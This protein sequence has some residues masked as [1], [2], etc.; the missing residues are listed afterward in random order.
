MWNISSSARIAYDSLLSSVPVLQSVLGGIEAFPGADMQEKHDFGRELLTRIQSKDSK[1][2]YEDRHPPIDQVW[3]Q[4]IHQALGQSPRW[5]ELLDKANSFGLES[6]NQAEL[7]TISWLLASMRD[8]LAAWHNWTHRDKEAYSALQNKVTFGISIDIESKNHEKR[9]TEY[10]Q[11]YDRYNEKLIYK[12]KP[13]EF[14][15]TLAD[16]AVD[17]ALKSLEI[18]RSGLLDGNM[19]GMSEPETPE[20]VSTIVQ[21]SQPQVQKILQLMGKLKQIVDVNLHKNTGKKKDSLRLE[22]GSDVSRLIVDEYLKDDDLF[23]LEF[24]ERKLKQYSQ[25]NQP[26]GDGP[27]VVIVD[28]TSSMGN[29]CGD[30]MRYEWA[31]AFALLVSSIASKQ[32]RECYFIGFGGY[33]KYTINNKD[34]RADKL[35]EFMQFYRLSST[36]WKP[37]IDKALEIIN[38]DAKFKK[39]DIMLITDGGDPDTPR[40]AEFMQNLATTKKRIDL[41]I[42]GIFVNAGTATRPLELLSAVADSVIHVQNLQDTQKLR[43]ALDA[44]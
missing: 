15:Q 27:I 16:Y 17:S 41:K 35:K 40:D 24:A 10:R 43:S 21:Y 6:K 25:K 13:T 31:K 7:C 23:F 3:K 33:V 38:S 4:A 26:K 28:E 14:C 18:S 5:Q 42:Y 44:L 34:I 22:S 37:G 20:K 30:Y 29:Y 12:N 2:F 39:A 32:K 19:P 9:L 11:A 36:Y 1:K 8:R